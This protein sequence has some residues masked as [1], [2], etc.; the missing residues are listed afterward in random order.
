M[1]VCRRILC[2]S[3]LTWLVTCSASEEIK[4]KPGEDVILP[5]QG[6]REGAIELLEWSKPDLGSE[7]YVFYFRDERSYEKYQHLLFH[8][9]V[10]LRDPQMKDG[11]VCV[12]LKNVS[13]SDTG[14][15]E[16]HVGYRGRSWLITTVTLSVK[17]SGGGAGRTEDGG[18]TGGGDKD[19]G[20]KDGHVGLV[21]GLS[22]LSVFVIAAVVGL[23]IFSKSKDQNSE[24]SKPNVLQK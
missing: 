16:C 24:L 22:V 18:D 13:I 3:F 8:G 19:G 6:P 1:C 15:Y 5:C 14:I 2:V 4:A 20:D 10:E 17:D 7:D 21:A 12:I 9:R 23:V 11:D